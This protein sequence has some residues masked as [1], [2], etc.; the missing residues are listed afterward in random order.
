MIGNNVRKQQWQIRTNIKLAV[1]DIHVGIH[2][3]HCQ[4]SRAKR[5]GMWCPSLLNGPN[6]VCFKVK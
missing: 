4:C 1:D 6:M 2:S 3:R 5:C